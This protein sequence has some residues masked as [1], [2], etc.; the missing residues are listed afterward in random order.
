MATTAWANDVEEKKKALFQLAA[1]FKSASVTE[2]TTVV[3]RAMV[4]I[5][6]FT[7]TPALGWSTRRQPIRPG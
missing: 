5:V 4:P 6:S 1:R 2:N 7:T 3:H